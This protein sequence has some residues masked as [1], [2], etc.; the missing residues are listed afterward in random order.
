VACHHPFRMWRHNG[1]V[2]LRR[3]E[4]DDREAVDMPC[5]GCLGCRMDRAR[6]WAIRNR[7][8]LAYHEKAC[9]TTL[10]YSDEN[11]P[12][13]RSIR[14]DH[15]SG[16]IKR[17]RARLSSEKIRF[18]GCGEYGERGGRPH[19]HAIL[20][21]IGGDETSILKAWPF[22][23]VGVHALTPS[24]IKYVAG[25]CAKKEGWHGE[26]REVLDKSTGEL[27]GREAP[28][29][30]MSRRPGIGG[31]A[32]KHFLSWSRYAVM[33]GTKFPVPRYLHEA[34]KKDADPQLVEEVQFERWKHRK[35]LTRDELDASE[36][37]A[38]ARL[39]LQSARRTYG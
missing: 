5:G 34:F 11:L 13:Y 26:F 19:Y 8:E 27:Y 24:A 6:S 39:S 1:K 7:L 9:W 35:A 31:E 25:Y 4:S 37:V 16:Y 3:P 18:F 36:A 17:L 2:T 38:K 20:Y 21:G 28:F 14:R 29:L 33:D 15:L 10:T 32:R 23:H 12:A 22:G 30:L